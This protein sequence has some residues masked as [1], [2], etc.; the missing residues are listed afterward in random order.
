MGQSHGAEDAEVISALLGFCRLGKTQRRA[1]LEHLNKF[2]Y[3]SPSQ[4]RQLI[5]GLLKL[6]NSPGISAIRMVAEQ[7]AVY[8][9]DKKK[10]PA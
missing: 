8:S 6:R 2:V 1:F 5:E 10:P 4:Q 3:A 9:N 7:A